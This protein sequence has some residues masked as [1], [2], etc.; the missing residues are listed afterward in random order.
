MATLPRLVALLFALNSSIATAAD[1]S[2]IYQQAL[3]HDSQLQAARSGLQATLEGEEQISAAYYPTLA[4]NANTLKNSAQ[5]NGGA[6]DSYD[7]RGYGI[8][9]NQGLYHRDI[10][11]NARE[12]R[13]GITQGELSYKLAQQGLILRV[14]NAYFELLSAQDGLEL[15]QAEKRAISQQLKQT[16]QRFDVGLSA[17]TDVHEAQAGFDMIVAQEISAQTL[18]DSSREALREI[19]GKEVNQITTLQA[20]LPYHLQHLPTSITGSN[21]PSTTI[22][23]SIFS[24]RPPKQLAMALIK[25][26]QDTIHL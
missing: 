9:L 13:S 14:A 3:T 8:T 5:T 21:W 2:S 10:I 12:I 22:L 4:L 19:V 24:V 1:L 7:S 16:K 18:L 23:H 15:A 26:M 11:V 17:I 20:N 25:P 6:T